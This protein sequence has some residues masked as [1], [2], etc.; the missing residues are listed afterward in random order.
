[1]YVILTMP[2]DGLNCRSPDVSKAKAILGWERLTD[3]CVNLTT[4]IV[5]FKNNQIKA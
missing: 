4:T 2:V 1:M 3:I 5:G